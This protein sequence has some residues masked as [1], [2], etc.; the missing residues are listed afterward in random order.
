[1]SILDDPENGAQARTDG[2][3]GKKSDSWKA[4]GTP[5]PLI[6]Q[7]HGLIGKPVSRIDGP[8]KVS[9]KAPFAAEIAMDAMLYAQIVFATIA[10]G[11]LA[12]LDTSAAEAAPGVAL[13]MTYHNAPRL[14]PMPVVFTSLK[15]GGNDGIP[16]L[17]DDRISWNGQPVAVVLAETQEQADHA[18]TLIRVDYVPETAVTTFAQAKANGTETAVFAGQPMHFEVGDAEAALAACEVRVEQIYLTPRHNHNP[19]EPNAV[20]VT[21]DGDRMILHDASQLVANTAW[22]LAQIFG[23]EEAQVEVRSPYVGG[24]FGGKCLWVH[25]VLAAAASKM[26]GRPVRMA[27]SREGV[28]RLIG[29]RSLTEQY[30]A[31]GADRSGRFKA[32]IHTGFSAMTPHNAIPERFILPTKAS[33]ASETMKLDVQVARMDMLSTTAMRAPGEAVGTFGIESAIDELAVALGMDPIELRILNEPEKDPLTGRAFSQRDIVKAWRD[34]AAAFGWTKRNPTPRATREGEWLIGLGCAKATYPYHRM[35]GGAARITI[36]KD[37]TALVEI[38]A[39][40]MGM[41]TATAQTVV[42]AARLG[43]E[44]AQ[45]TFAYGDSSLPG[46]VIAGGSQQTASIG[47][48][49]MA[50]ERALVGE[51]IK[52]AGNDSP[53]AGLEAHEVAGLNGGLAKIVEPGRH[54]SYVSILAR[55]GREAFA[56][57][58][59]APP[60]MELEQWSMHSHGALFCEVAV[61]AVTGEPRVRRLLGAFDCGRIIN[62]KTAASQLRG[63][64]IMGLGLALTEETLF[65]ERSGRIVNPN[66]AEYHVPVHL[67]VPAI[68]ILWTD[69]P[70]PR[71]PMGAR[72]VGEIGITGVGAA[73]ANAI[74]NATA[75]RVR[76]V[77]IT[78]DKLLG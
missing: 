49:V 68:E 46:V 32:I 58:A 20:T 56:I 65:D 8:L 14:A 75:I 70:D 40:D 48:A 73:V 72:G 25:Q 47:S 11:R 1:M 23:I 64:M 42:A 45:V 31:I 5:D 13:V 21:W 15:A 17:Q 61:S 38:A 41:G 16:I 54:E 53:I 71:A 57:E 39:H 63:G 18:A 43:L 24:G 22:S 29:G 35:P 69:I 30:V 62:P 52:L 9:G 2:L 36:R 19:I 51:L 4:G 59:E 28:Y 27:L 33:Y 78:L 60:P 7:K 77:P 66:F 3:M 6:H 34:G 55:A 67:D 76:E 44:P 26:V 50:A 12:R 74:Y 10:K 37:G